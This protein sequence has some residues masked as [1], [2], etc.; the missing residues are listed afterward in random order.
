MTNTLPAPQRQAR[1]KKPAVPA[2]NGIRDRKDFQNPKAVLAFF[3]ALRRSSAKLL[4]LDPDH[5]SAAQQT[6]VDRCASLRMQLDRWQSQQL[7]N[8]EIDVRSFISASTELERLLGGSPAAPTS[9]LA[10]EES[11]N[12]L[13]RLIE[14]TLLAAPV[15]DPDE[16]ERMA[17]RMRAEEQQALVAAGVDVFAPVRPAPRADNVV[18][19]DARERANANLPPAHYLRDGQPREPWRDFYDGAVTGP[20]PWPLR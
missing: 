14:T 19:I 8:Q 18:P 11:R 20:P 16:A 2:S 13:R 4:K 6:R 3:E 1:T 9:V 17:E 5:L 7:S 10:S 12:K 15:A